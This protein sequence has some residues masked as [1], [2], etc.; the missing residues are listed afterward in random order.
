[1]PSRLAVFL[2]RDGVLNALVPRDG[3]MVSPRSVDD[4]VL[5]D[6]VPGAVRRLRERGVLVFVTTNQPDIARGQLS[7]DALTEM[8]AVLRDAIA[9]DEVLVCTHDDGDGCECRKPAPGMMIDLATRWGV[10]LASSFVVGD[11]WRD[12]EA[13]RRAG[14]RTVLVDR[15]DAAAGGA[16]ADLTVRTLSDAVAHITAESQWKTA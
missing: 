13:G 12:I 3:R 2:D 10:D 11:S 9:P 7:P 16:I 4:F 6:D 8:T 15:G 14:C 5:F 1:M